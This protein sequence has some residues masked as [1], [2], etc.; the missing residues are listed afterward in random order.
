M[1]I[2]LILPFALLLLICASRLQAQ[3]IVTDRP[4]QTESSLTVPRGS[5][6]IETG[7]AFA[8]LESDGFLEKNFATPSTLFRVGITRWLELR[9]VNQV[10]IYK[11][12]KKSTAGIADPEIGVKLQVLDKEN[13]NATIAFITHVVIPTGTKGFSEENFGT[14]NKIA[15][16]HEIAKKFGIGYNI[17]YRYFG[18]G[19]G[20]L[21]YSLAAGFDIT[22]KLG[23]YCEPFGEFTNLEDFI[24]NAD[25]GF[26]YRV[27]DN[28]Q[29]DFAYGTGL[30][31]EMNYVGFGLS[32]RIP[33]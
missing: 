12:L 27:Y 5:L 2:H 19:S 18:H 26:T 10:E 25:I 1:K 15:V 8:F 14:V 7:S 13:I 31:N 9:L 33:E 6:Q 3:E 28:L 11:D 17:G 22:D 32:W 20:D 16:S 24:L 30:N 23:M 21:I 4:D 29:L